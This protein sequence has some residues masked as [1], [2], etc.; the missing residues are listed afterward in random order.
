MRRH[1]RGIAAGAIAGA[2]A[3]SGFSVSAQDTTGQTG[4]GFSPDDDL[5]C[6]LY[7][8]SLMGES[9]GVMTP[10]VASAYLGSMTYFIGR[11]EAQRGK[12][13]NV[14]LSERYPEFLKQDV[15][16][17]EQICGLR[18]RGFAS[19]METISRVLSDAQREAQ[20]EGNAQNDAQAQE[21]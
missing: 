16:Q 7:V 15:R 6:A 17:L 13:I 20:A 19:R 10:D 18:T 21:K 4:Q 3:L 5:D 8:A 2:L 12:P 11:Y 14:A 1:G 9:E